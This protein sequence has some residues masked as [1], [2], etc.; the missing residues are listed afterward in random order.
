M[1]PRPFARHQKESAEEK[2]PSKGANGV[3]QFFLSDPRPDVQAPESPESPGSPESAQSVEDVRPD[4]APSEQVPSIVLEDHAGAGWYPDSVDPGLMRYWD[5]FHLTGQVMHVHARV[6]EA[7]A[8][9]PAR[10]TPGVDEP[11]GADRSSTHSPVRATDPVAPASSQFTP[12]HE[13]RSVASGGQVPAFPPPPS[14]GFDPGAG[15][16]SAL[17]RSVA[18]EQSR[19]EQ[20]VDPNDVFSAVRGIGMAEDETDDDGTDDTDGTDETDETG[21]SG[22][23]QAPDASVSGA[24]ESENGHRFGVAPPATGSSRPMGSQG[25]EDETGFWVQET[26]RA[27]AKARSVGTPQAWQE[28]SRAAVVV[29][30]MAQTMQA[31]ADAAQEAAAMDRAAQEAAERADVAAR[32][33]SDANQ[34][35]QR[36]AQAAEGAAEAARVAEQE[37]VEARRAAA[38]AKQTAEETA[39]AAPKLAEEAR[40]AAQAATGAEHKRQGLDQIVARACTAHTPTAWSEALRLS[41]QA[42]ESEPAPVSDT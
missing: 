42:M 7:G 19:R 2:P 34:S 30:E 32:K 4:Q 31:A 41:S 25:P 27:V 12:P 5:G 28:A 35:V 9:A 20:P 17:N 21:G 6:G 11:S 29:S 40:L 10:A 3:A 8:T 37:A 13:L 26:E 22:A 18:P 1:A 14:V 16:E 38:E 33:A 23:D 15:T 24:S 36:T 39:Q